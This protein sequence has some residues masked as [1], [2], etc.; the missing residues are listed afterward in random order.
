MTLTPA[1]GHGR[2]RARE[3][4]TADFCTASVLD[5]GLI[6]D[7]RHW[8]CGEA[9]FRWTA[10]R[11]LI[12]LT[13]RGTT[14]RT[15]IYSEGRL[16]HDGR[17]APG[18]LSF[19]PAGAERSGHFRDADLVY[20]ALW[21]DPALELPGCDKLAQLPMRINEKGDAVIRAL[22]KSF[23]EEM[24]AGRVPEA[25]YVEQLLGLVA[26]RIAGALPTA[27]GR[28]ANRLGKGLLARMTDY[29]DSHLDAAHSLSDL[30]EVAGMPVDA[31]ARR[32]KAE[33]G[34][35]PYAYVIARRVLRAQCEL[36]N[37][38]TPISTLALDL[39]FSSQSHFTTT[40]HRLTGT[41][42]RA[43]RAGLSQDP[44]IPA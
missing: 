44:D 33:T 26:M 13:E 29:I 9:E 10:P 32:F 20:T 4:R 22:V 24:V 38:S 15:C 8:A 11:H 2:L 31:F 3:A 23:S 1:V 19:V 30:A 5:G 41:T 12:V 28:R 35:A 34:M 39:G 14:G 43:Y 37:G 7:H 42:P 16:M 27:P 6:F 25:G 21:L 18:T 40:F 17:D 36:E